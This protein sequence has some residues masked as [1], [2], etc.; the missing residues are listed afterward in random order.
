M[1]QVGGEFVV[2]DL[3]NGFVHQLNEAAGFILSRCDGKTS[4]EMIISALVE[5]YAIDEELARRDVE[6][7]MTKFGELDLLAKSSL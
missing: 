3:H 1:R 4:T 7:A 6:M 2:L 5:M